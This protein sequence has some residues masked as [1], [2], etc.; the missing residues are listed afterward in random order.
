V[1]FTHHFHKV[2]EESG[3]LQGAIS[4]LQVRHMRELITGAGQRFDYRTFPDVGHVMHGSDPQLYSRTL[5]EW[6]A[7]LAAA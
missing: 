3:R 6:I 7:T 5:R 4:D 2:D 1:L